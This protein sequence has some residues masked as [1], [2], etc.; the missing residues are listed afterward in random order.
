M[1][2]KPLP[3]R[4][5]IIHRGKDIPKPEDIHGVVFCKVLAPYKLDF[6]ILPFNRNKR[7]VFELC[8]FCMEAMGKGECHHDE[9]QRSFV[10][11]FCNP[12]LH[13]A[14]KKGLKRP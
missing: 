8:R 6:P 12:E 13:E 3:T 14:I 7:L 9:E 1:S 5:P 4:K 11:T 2:R 10:G